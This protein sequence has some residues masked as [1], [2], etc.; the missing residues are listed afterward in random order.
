MNASLRSGPTSHRGMILLAVLI[1][2]PIAVFAAAAGMYSVDG[3]L[4]SEI[5][6]LKSAQ[7]R[8]LAW[9]GVQAVMA[10]LGDQRAAIVEGREPRVT[11]EWEL[12][13]EASGARGIVRLLTVGDGD[14]RIESESAKLDLNTATA[15]MLAKAPGLDQPSARAVARA[16]RARPVM[17]VAE[18]ARLPEIAALGK[19]GKHDP[20]GAEGSKKPGLDRVLTAFSFE[21]AIQFGVGSDA[22]DLRGKRRVDVNLGLTDALGAEIDRRFGQALGA[23]VKTLVKGAEGKIKTRRDLLRQM[24]AA[25]IEPADYAVVLDAFEAGIDPYQPG[26]VDLN[27]A[28]AEV[29]ACIPG[30]SADLA[31]KIVQAR[32]SMA[33]EQ[34]T[35][36]AWLVTQGLLTP[37]QFEQ[38]APWVTTRSFQWRVLV[39]AGVAESGEAS[40]SKTMA[41]I[42]L[43]SRIVLEAVID[44][45]SER[46]RLAYLRDVTMLEAAGDMAA[47]LAA[48]ETPIEEASPSPAPVP[49]PAPRPAPTSPPAPP[50][51]E[52]AAPAPP[53][54]PTETDRRLGRW[55]AGG[56]QSGGGR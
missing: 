27:R 43:G 44:L 36:P 38:A 52:A 7:A 2:I 55:T 42:R 9:S 40:E 25:G 22:S 26:R 39:E 16:R 51:T 11:T 17:G 48:V 12:H 4:T 15:A 53:P 28:T 33:K 45:S 21:P 46:A 41:D 37:E 50:K 8:A 34:L 56:G 49:A 47:E 23:K 29:L 5:A 1:I 24:R 31:K 30:V 13:K 32:E 18:L 14:S 3:R 35:S 6:S 19:S 54:A 20:V 10:E